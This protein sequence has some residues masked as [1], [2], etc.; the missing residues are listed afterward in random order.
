VAEA[1]QALPR[2]SGG[3]AR[4]VGATRHS[5]DGL[6][7]AWGEAAF[8]L[9]VRCA[10]VLV[11]G[12]VWLGRGW[13]E[14]AVLAGTVMIVLI[15]ELLNSAVEAA[16]DRVGPEWHPLAKRAKDIGSAAVMLSLLLCGATWAAA[17]HARLVG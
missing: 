11:P 1:P 15:T 12:A 8:R 3:W 4:L 9:E 6:H 2:Q 7:A 5:L 16:V 13:L 17:L 10:F 14:T